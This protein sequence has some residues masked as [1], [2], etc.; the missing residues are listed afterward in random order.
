MHK[1]QGFTLLEVLVAL[2]I[3]AIAL[4]A[5][6]KTTTENAENARYLRDKTLA[7]WVAM[8]A[9]TQIQVWGEWPAVGKKE[10]T[11]MMAEREWYW[12][13]KVSETADDELRRLD[14]EVYFVRRDKTPITTLVGFV[15]SPSPGI[16]KSL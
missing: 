7:H 4:S 12:I 10:G 5:A 8:N 3:L 9:L 16:D 11:A 6:I 14:I 15:G 13:I 1:K 2:A